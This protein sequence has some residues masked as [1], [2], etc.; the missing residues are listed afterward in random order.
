MRTIYQISSL[1]IYGIIVFLGV[2]CVN[3]QDG[4]PAHFYNYGPAINDN[5]VP[6]NDDGS[7]GPVTISIDFPFF[8]SNHASLY[9]SIYICKVF[10]YFVI[11]Y[12][13]I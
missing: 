9:V 7:S 4:Q 2:K 5:P 3:A 13:A 8:D 6:I 12:R 1:C 10:F 11:K